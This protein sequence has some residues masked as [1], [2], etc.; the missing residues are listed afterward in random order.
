MPSYLG[1]ARA[2]YPGTPRGGHVLSPGFRYLT[3]CRAGGAAFFRNS[4]FCCCCNLSV[5]LPRVSV[6]EHRPLPMAPLTSHK[7]WQTFGA[8]RALASDAR[9]FM[10]WGIAH[11]PQG[12]AAKNPWG[13][14]AGI[15]RAKASAC[16]GVRTPGF[17]LQELLTA[18]GSGREGGGRRRAGNSN[19]ARELV[20]LFDRRVAR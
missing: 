8:M 10:P 6:F 11:T 12:R 15:S 5:T 14:G 7:P 18:C 2:M 4:E 9:R 17:R 3:K 20:F 13:K 19:I 1:E 16:N